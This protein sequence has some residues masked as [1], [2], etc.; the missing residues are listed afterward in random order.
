MAQ[1]ERKLDRKEID[2]VLRSWNTLAPAISQ[3][4]IDQCEQLL[5]A[6]VHGKCR[7]YMIK[8]INTRMWRLKTIEAEHE[9]M[10]S[11]GFDKPL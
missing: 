11:L 1:K 3:Y 2:E 5:R 6:E 8:R 10:E 4:T 9:L 7:P